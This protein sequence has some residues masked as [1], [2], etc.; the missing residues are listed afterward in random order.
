M[1]K[2]FYSLLA[3]GLVA[4]AGAKAQD[5]ASSA[6][7]MGASAARDDLSAVDLDREAGDLIRFQ[8]A[9]EAAA[10]ILQVARDTMQ[11]I[12]NAV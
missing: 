10:R 6:R 11:T 9:Y 5:A 12:F 8:Q 3:C 7:A 1:K 4:L 2:T